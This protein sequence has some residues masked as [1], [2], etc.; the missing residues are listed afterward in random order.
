MVSRNYKAL[1]MEAYM[2]ALQRS[3][4]VQIISSD[5]DEQMDQYDNVLTEHLCHKH[6]PHKEDT[7]TI[8]PFEH[9]CQM[10]S[11]LYQESAE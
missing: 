5:P 11:I 4:N 1:D 6:A 3:K 9:R 7:I 2:A 10:R 8:Q